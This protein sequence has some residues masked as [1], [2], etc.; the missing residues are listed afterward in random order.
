MEKFAIV[1]KN[2]KML[3]ISLR[4]SLKLPQKSINS[5]FSLSFLGGCFVFSS[6]AKEYSPRPEGA[7]GV[8][9]F[10]FVFFSF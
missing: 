5:N 4:R 9:C 8:C 6:M 1:N 3:Q 10:H 7:G 2:N